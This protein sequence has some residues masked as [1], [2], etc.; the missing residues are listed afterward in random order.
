MS[1][2]L[3]NL[4]LV[5]HGETAWS[6]SGQ[7]TGRTDI[8]LT[9][10]GEHDALALSAR[11]RG[12]SLTKVLS[13]PL[14]RAWRTG[15]LAGFGERM[16]PDADLM[17]WDYGAYEGRRTSDIRTEHPGWRLF[18]DGCPGGETLVEV[19]MRAERIITRVRALEGDVLV[20]AHRD[21]FR[22]LI[23]RWVALPALEARR[24]HLA[25]ASLS[26]LGY[27]HDLDEPVIRVLNDV[28][29]P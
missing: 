18:E 17:E 22:I 11:L 21:I 16:E 5:R 24:L 13:S 8:P 10:R 23:A 29:H 9:E 27:D 19:S 6:I 26:V 20:F 3:P 12:L 1:G 28:R 7:H 14:Q 2:A 15:D 4:Y 25:T